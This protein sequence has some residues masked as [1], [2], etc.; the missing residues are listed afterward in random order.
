MD[1]RSK[2]VSDQGMNKRAYPNH[3]SNKELMRLNMSEK[4][5]MTSAMINARTQVTATMPVHDA[6]PMN[7]FECRCLDSLK[8]RKKTKRELTDCGQN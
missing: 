4:K 1:Q 5:G 7:V 6:H 2:L 3:P 8:R